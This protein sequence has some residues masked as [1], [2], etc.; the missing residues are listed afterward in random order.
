[1]H[2]S[3]NKVTKG[4]NSVLPWKQKN[5]LRTHPRTRTLT[6]RPYRQGTQRPCPPATGR[7]GTQG[8]SGGWPRRSRTVGPDPRTRAA[9]S[10]DKS[11]YKLQTHSFESEKIMKKMGILGYFLFSRLICCVLKRL[12]DIWNLKKIEAK[13]ICWKYSSERRSQN[14]PFNWEKK[15]LPHI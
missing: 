1:M 10:P 3:K 6:P 5:A 4:V 7:R 15:S 11:P 2:W 12:F 14:L 8:P 13:M 9:N